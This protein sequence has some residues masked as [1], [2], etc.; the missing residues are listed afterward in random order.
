MKNGQ[1]IEI[2]FTDRKL[3]SITASAGLFQ[4]P[5][6]EEHCDIKLQAGGRY[7]RLPTSKVAIRDIKRSML[8]HEWSVLMKETVQDV[9]V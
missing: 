8:S 1:Q 4:M 2:S 5:T 7:V 3:C 9:I 6:L